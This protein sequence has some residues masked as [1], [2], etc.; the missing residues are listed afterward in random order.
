[1][2][3]LPEESPL[4]SPPEFEA[5]GV[6]LEGVHPIKAPNA[7]EPMTNKLVIY[8]FFMFYLPPSF[9]FLKNRTVAPIKAGTQMMAP[10]EAIAPLQP[11]ALDLAVIP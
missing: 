4:I 7:I 11:E 9:L 10:N 5:D 6:L 3:G 1:M 2:L 8:L